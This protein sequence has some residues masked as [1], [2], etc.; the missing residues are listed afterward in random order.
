MACAVE[1]QQESWQGKWVKMQWLLDYTCENQFGWINMTESGRGNTSEEENTELY[2]DTI[3]WEHP[4]KKE[5]GW[6]VSKPNN[7]RRN[8][9]TIVGN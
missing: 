1:I 7:W 2:R 4:Q 6:G 8:I 3:M 9:E 5:R